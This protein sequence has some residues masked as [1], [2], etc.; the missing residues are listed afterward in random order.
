MSSISF[1]SKN[2]KHLAELSDKLNE[3]VIILKKLYLLGM[4]KRRIADFQAEKFDLDQDSASTYIYHFLEEI[5]HLIANED[6]VDDMP[7]VLKDSLQ[8]A[9]E[10]EPFLKKD[11]QSLMDQLNR[12][13][14]LNQ[15][16]FDLLE[17]LLSLVDIDRQKVFRKLRSK[18]A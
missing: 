2:Y 10:T 4:P 6:E 14:P 1:L 8:S 13:E 11:L 17:K 15:T 3:A 9:A 18:R 12:Q 16:H 7:Q 5:N